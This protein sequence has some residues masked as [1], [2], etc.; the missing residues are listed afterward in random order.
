CET[1]E[2]STKKT[3]EFIERKEQLLH[4][5]AVSD[6]PNPTFTDAAPSTPPS[7]ATAPPPPP[8]IESLV[9]DSAAPKSHRPLHPSSD[10]LSVVAAPSHLRFSYHTRDN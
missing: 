4:S 7:R 9:P 10:L 3:P 6:S 5:S 2:F 1:L 8:Q